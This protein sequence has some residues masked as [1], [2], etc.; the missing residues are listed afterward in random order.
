M[1][2][3]EVIKFRHSTRAFKNKEIEP[4]K[5]KAILET[6]QTAP[7]AGNL[8]AYKINLVLNPEIRKKL[9]EAALNQG[10]VSQAPAVLVFSAAPQKSAAKYGKRGAELYSIQEATIAAAFAWLKIVDLGLSACWVGAFDER[11]VREILELPVNLRPIVILPI[12][13]KL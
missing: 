3:D 9:A 7:S 1:E 5:L 12:G 13:Y 2:F 11:A 4:E 6:A 10:F 8:R